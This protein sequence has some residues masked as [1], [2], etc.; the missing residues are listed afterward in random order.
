MV[1]IITGLGEQLCVLTTKETPR[2]VPCLTDL[3]LLYNPEEDGPD[4]DGAGG[5][6]VCVLTTKETPRQVLYGRTITTS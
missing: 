6:T 1:Q 2:Q 4:H 3:Y 5:A